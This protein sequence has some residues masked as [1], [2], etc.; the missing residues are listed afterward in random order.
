MSPSYEAVS[1]DTTMS[2]SMR[3]AWPVPRELKSVYAMQAPPAQRRE[4]PDHTACLQLWRRWT[5]T[6][7]WRSPRRMSLPL[8]TACRRA[9]SRS[10]GGRMVAPGMLSANSRRSRPSLVSISYHAEKAHNRL[11]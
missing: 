9:L 10:F 3:T 11:M 6:W 7:P 8:M 5:W 1:I 4:A 2:C